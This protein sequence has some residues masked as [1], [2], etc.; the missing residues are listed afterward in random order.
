MY[1]IYTLVVLSSLLLG[2]CSSQKPKPTVEKKVFL[3]PKVKNLFYEDSMILYGLR[4]E[5]LHEWDSAAS[6]FDKL[7]IK[8]NQ[9][10]YLYRSL[11][12]NLEAK[13]YQ[14]VLKR[15]Q[16]FKIKDIILQRAEIIAYMGLKKF[17]FV[18]SQAYSLV[19]KTKD[20]EDYL[21]MANIYLHLNQAK[22]SLAILEKAYKINYDNKV[23]VAIASILYTQLDQKKEAIKRLELHREINGN[24]L[25]V[26]MRLS[27]FYSDQK[28]LDHLLR[29]YLAL[30]RLNHN[31]QVA[32]KIIEI[33]EYKQEYLQLEDFL[34]T[35]HTNDKK[36]LELYVA[37]KKFQKASMLALS[38][39]NERGDINYLA[40]SALYQYEVY[41]KSKKKKILDE[42]VKKFEKYVKEKDVAVYNNYLGYLL[43]DHDLDIKKGIF[44]VKK[45]LQEEPNSAFILDSLAWG[46]YKEGAC[47]KANLIM[48]KV[49]TLD[50]D[51]E[52]IQEHIKAIKKCNI[53]RSN[54]K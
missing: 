39:Y 40:E 22:K 1:K 52:D 27:S 50:K 7:Y 21:R 2:G 14:K 46:Y 47:H 42:V 5:E 8:Y 11:Q 45:A 37:T 35:Y 28:D 31:I 17:T 6:F 23:I 4:A 30:Y 29:T 18:E 49:I 48:Q 16:K 43:I 19:E 24:S 20:V 54:K 32:S 10:E 41:K 25:V 53:Q 44:Y 9:K 33:Y 38:L 26:L 34:A 12:D 15:V 3:P 51:N 36:L 13:E